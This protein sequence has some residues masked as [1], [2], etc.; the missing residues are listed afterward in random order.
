MTRTPRRLLRLNKKLA[1]VAT[2]LWAVS[3][4]SKAIR[5]S[6]PATGPHTGRIRPAANRGYNICNIALIFRKSSQ[7]ISVHVS[8]R[9]G[10]ADENHDAVA[11]RIPPKV[12]NNIGFPIVN[13]PD[14]ASLI[15]DH[16]R[17]THH[18]D[19]TGRSAWTVQGIAIVQQH[20][21]TR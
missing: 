8:R 11:T 13:R 16:G 12:D 14:V 6:R 5:G 4:M 1:A 2:A 9:G 15:D 19:E 10:Q 18:W 3:L 20:F 7:R 21:A 17:L